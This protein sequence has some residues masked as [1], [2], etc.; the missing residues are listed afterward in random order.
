MKNASGKITDAGQILGSIGSPGRPFLRQNGVTTILP[1]IPGGTVE[2]SAGD[3]NDLGQ[4]I[5]SVSGVPVIWQHGAAADLN[6]QIA[7]TDPL[8]PYVHLDVAYLINNLGEIVAIGHDS[9]NTD[10]SQTYLLTPGN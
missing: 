8:R 7:P 1:P 5:G 9:R 6:S 3:I 10:F 2:G 4:I